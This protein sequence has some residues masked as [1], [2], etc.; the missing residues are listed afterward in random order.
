MEDAITIIEAL[1]IFALIIGGVSAVGKLAVR[2]G[3]K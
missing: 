2:R 1:V 3:W